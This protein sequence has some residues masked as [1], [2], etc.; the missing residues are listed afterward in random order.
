MS[1]ASGEPESERLERLRELYPEVFAEGRVDLAKLATVLGDDADE[2]PE[3]YSFSW[4]GKRDAIRLLQVPS[5][6]ALVPARDE[7]VEF[8]ATQHVFIEG[9]NLESLKLLRRAYAG[10]VR[11]SAHQQPRDQ[12][13]LPLRL[14]FESAG[15]LTSVPVAWPQRRPGYR[16]RFVPP[17]LWPI[18]KAEATA[19]PRAAAVWR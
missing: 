9:E 13:P 7:S 18:A 8:D 16:R 10:R 12:R 4:A 15:A 17:P 6:A 3:R 2:R 19:A 1:R 14:A 5:R 11:Q